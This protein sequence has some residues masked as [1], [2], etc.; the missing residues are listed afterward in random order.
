MP[1]P[2]TSVLDNFNRSSLGGNWTSESNG[3]GN[4]LGDLLTSGSTVVVGN[5]STTSDGYWNASTFNADQEAYLDVPTAPDA[6]NGIGIYLRLQNPG[7]TSVIWYWWSYFNGTGFRWI[8]GISGG[9]TAQIGSTVST[10]TLVSGDSLWA[11][12]A[13]TT[14]TGYHEHSGTWTQILQVTDSNITGSG[15]IGIRLRGTV[16]QG[17]NFGGGS[18]SAIDAAT[19]A[20]V[21]T[22]SSSESVDYVETI[23]IPGIS[24][25][26]HTE[27][28]ALVDSG[29]VP[30][31][32]TPSGSDIYTPAG[33][34]YSDAATP[35]SKTAITD[36]DQVAYLD[37]IPP[38]SITTPA[39]T[40]E[41]Q[42]TTK[43]DLSGTAYVGQPLTAT[44][45]VDVPTQSVGSGT[46]GSGNVVGGDTDTSPTVPA[47]FWGG[48]DD[49]N[50][51]IP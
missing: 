29:V 13:G 14:L 12:A 42:T 6:G 35:I 33:I 28:A 47:G 34:I 21:T 17:D 8:R 11:T 18:I 10:P 39:V 27:L 48:T 44:I 31:I 49:D 20:G 51:L 46:S 15:R 32:T 1:A 7:S 5:T 23:V 45:E 3:T 37:S 25:P 36:S 26:S 50:G 40:V 38:R 2:T 43:I 22:P 16:V 30:G 9:T 24:T 41:L 19:V 4:G